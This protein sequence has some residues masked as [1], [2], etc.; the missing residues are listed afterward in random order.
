MKHL[1]Y[2]EYDAILVGPWR[3]KFLASPWPLTPGTLLLLPAS[4]GKKLVAA[5]LAAASVAS[6][7]KSLAEP[8]TQEP[9][10]L[11]SFTRPQ[12]SALCDSEL[13]IP[14]LRPVLGS[15]TRACAAVQ[16]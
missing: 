2:S 6:V 11:L 13:L 16:A 8:W 5:R 15:Q 10:D 1:Q 14:S 12:L 3:L 9:L 4:G 7:C